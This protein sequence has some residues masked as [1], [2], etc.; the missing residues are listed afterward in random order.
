LDLIRYLP[1]E[2]P[3]TGILR[4][5][6]HLSGARAITSILSKLGKPGRWLAAARFDF[7][8]PKAACLGH[9]AQS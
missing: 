5:E 4:V 6:F 1:G 7:T 3:E 9:P 8:P 2:M